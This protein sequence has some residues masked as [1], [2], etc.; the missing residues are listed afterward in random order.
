MWFFENKNYTQPQTLRTEQVP[1]ARV[2][3][4]TSPLPVIA[5]SDDINA[6]IEASFSD[7][8]KGQSL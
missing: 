1:L 4:Q 7:V 8:D 3:E 6:A 5:A 2:V